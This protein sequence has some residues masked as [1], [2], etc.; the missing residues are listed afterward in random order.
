M[1]ERTR[2]FADH[3]QQFVVKEDRAALAALRRGLGRQVGEAPEMFPYVVPFIPEGTY[4]ADEGAYYLVA[5]LVAFHPA[6]TQ[7]TDFGGSLAGLRSVVESKSLEHRFV[8]LLG[9]HPE[10]LPDH[11]RRH[12]ALLKVHD[13]AWDW[14]RLLD[15]VRRWGHPDRFVQRAWARSFW[16]SPKGEESANEVVANKEA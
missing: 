9:C 4:P 14:E 2:R 13:R 11:L 3:L 6:R 1:S 12:V 5:S 8:A 10:A 16:R 15:D 7:G